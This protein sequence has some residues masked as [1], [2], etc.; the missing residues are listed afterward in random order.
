MQHRRDCPGGNRSHCG[1]ATAELPLHAPSDATWL[2]RVRTYVHS[3]HGYHARACVCGHGHK[4]G[5]H[6]EQVWTVMASSTAVGRRIHDCVGN[7][8]RRCLHIT[9][10]PLLGSLWKPPQV[11]RR[12]PGVPAT[13]PL[14]QVHGDR[15]EAADQ[16]R[17]VLLQQDS[18]ARCRQ[19]SNLAP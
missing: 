13:M 16:A 14:I 15:R 17:P 9:C 10:H 7:L 2:H 6:R 19:N 3:H 12:S 18:I 1:D 8:S 5:H 4:A 11:L